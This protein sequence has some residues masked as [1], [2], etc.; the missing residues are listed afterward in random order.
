MNFL[1]GLKEQKIDYAFS[2][3]HEQIYLDCTNARGDIDIFNTGYNGVIV[4][5]L[6]DKKAVIGYSDYTFGNASGC[7]F[8]IKGSC[9][10]DLY[11]ENSNT[12]YVDVKAGSGM[13]VVIRT[14]KFTQG[15]VKVQTS[16][17]DI[18]VYEITDK[19]SRLLDKENNQYS[20]IFPIV[21]DGERFR[22]IVDSYSLFKI[23]FAEY[24]IDGRLR[25]GLASGLHLEGMDIECKGNETIIVRRNTDV[26]YMAGT[27]GR[28]VGNPR[29]SWKIHQD[30]YKDGVDGL[31]KLERYN[32]AFGNADERA[33]YTAGYFGV[34]RSVIEKDHLDFAI[35]AGAYDSDEV[36]DLVNHHDINA[37][38][39]YLI[40]NNLFVRV[41]V[42][43][44]S[45]NLWGVLTNPR[46][47]IVE[48]CFMTLSNGKKMYPEITV[49]LEKEKPMLVGFAGSLMGNTT[50]GK[51]HMNV[52]IY[53]GDRVSSI[54]IDTQGGAVLCWDGYDYVILG[55]GMRIN[56]VNS[57]YGVIS[58]VA[59]PIETTLGDIYVYGNWKDIERKHDRFMTVKCEI[60]AQ[61][62]LIGEVFNKMLR[63]NVFSNR[64]NTIAMR[65]SSDFK[66]IDIIKGDRQ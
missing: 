10:L 24:G 20:Y 58:T 5:G 1:E 12:I 9:I 22:R 36:Y 34:R 19:Q 64:Y 6:R 46:I 38:T 28:L 60:K 14:C 15:Y 33:W 51:L 21:F 2:E 30:L 25:L 3:H 7:S 37:N 26:V 47:D 57:E 66:V 13:M 43:R 39:G 16:L 50:V 54:Y 62:G 29:A 65:V 59:E 17:G 31:E 44:S 55:N 42:G 41:L 48:S 23:A 8:L 35:N 63:H 18:D 11:D 61:K 45:Y 56:G 4:T 32:K 49:W 27:E 40:V 53:A 52:W